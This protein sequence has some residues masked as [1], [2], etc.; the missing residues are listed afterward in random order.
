MQEVELPTNK[1]LHCELE[2]AAQELV[3]ISIQRYL[4]GC[5]LIGLY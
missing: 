4:L 3:D 1:A 5:S 2:A